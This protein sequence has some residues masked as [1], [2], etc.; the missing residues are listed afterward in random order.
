MGADNTEPNE[1]EIETL[2]NKGWE[3]KFSSDGEE[4]HKPFSF[5]DQEAYMLFHANSGGLRKFYPET[6]YRFVFSKVGNW[7]V[8]V[9]IKNTLSNRLSKSELALALEINAFGQ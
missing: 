4:L 5:N 3:V 6:N 7:S 1:E 9:I 2:L 8:G